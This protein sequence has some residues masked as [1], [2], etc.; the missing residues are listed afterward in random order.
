MIVIHTPIHT[1]EERERERAREREQ[2][3]FDR[4]RDFW[5]AR[6]G[7]FQSEITNHKHDT[8]CWEK[9]TEIDDF[10]LFLHSIVMFLLIL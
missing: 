4:A 7:E 8:E 1:T 9:V 10:S 2:R 6:E 5:Q 3:K